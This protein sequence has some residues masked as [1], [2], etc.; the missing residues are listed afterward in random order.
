MGG[1]KRRAEGKA[2]GFHCN[3]MWDIHPPGR[4]TTGED[5]GRPFGT[6]GAGQIEC[7]PG[8]GHKRRDA[9]GTRAS[10]EEE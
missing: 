6:G 9:T 7:T 8:N 10:H 3:I 5:R 4:T 1:M 2:E